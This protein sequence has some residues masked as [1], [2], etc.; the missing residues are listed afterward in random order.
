MNELDENIRTDVQKALLAKPE[1]QAVLAQQPE[2]EKK[3]E[4]ESTA[5]CIIEILG[6][7]RLETNS[8]DE[9]EPANIACCVDFSYR[10]KTVKKKDVEKQYI[11]HFKAWKALLNSWVNMSSSEI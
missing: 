6:V 8:D 1:A 3:E 7:K 11:S 2:E 4:E 10:D 9:N 5:T